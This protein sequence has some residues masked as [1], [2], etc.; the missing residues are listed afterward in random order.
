MPSL[1]AMRLWMLVHYARRRM[2][3]LKPGDQPIFSTGL[4]QP[5]DESINSAIQHGVE[6]L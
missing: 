5:G 4:V 2:L 6:R 3:W 1:L